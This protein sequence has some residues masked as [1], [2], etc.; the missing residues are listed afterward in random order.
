MKQLI[1]ISLVFFYS[2]STLGVTLLLHTCGGESETI[3]AATSAEDPC[4]CAEMM[5]DDRC[6]TTELT[7]VKIDDEHVF[8]A[9]VIVEQPP[10]AALAAAALSSHSGP[11][12]DRAA[13]VSL[14]PISP[15]PNNDLH[16]FNSVFLI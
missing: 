14:I 13:G 7:T 2:A 5:P 8:T 4:G 12:E 10:M 11:E 16:I 3:I 1:A 6:C 15:P 9:P